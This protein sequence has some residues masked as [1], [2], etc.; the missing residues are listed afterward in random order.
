MTQGCRLLIPEPPTSGF[1]TGEWMVEGGE[2]SD[3]LQTRVTLLSRIKN[4]EDRRAW[5]EFV[6]L[7]GLV[8]YNFCSKRG[9]QSADVEDVV[10]EALRSVASAIQNF[11]YD[12]AKGTF[13]GWLFRVV[14]SKLND[15]FRKAAKREQGTGRTTI[16]RM[17]EE[18][19]SESEIEEWDEEYHRYVFRWAADR[20]K[21]QVTK[22]SWSAFWMTA[23]E[24]RDPAEVANE[25]GME[26][27]AVYVAKSRVIS[28]LRDTVEL[29][30]GEVLDQWTA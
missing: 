2:V 1:Q 10:Q 21:P 3:E 14:R 12:P 8:L 11:E 26:R 15:H 7:Y 25:L 24:E 29:A 6:D 16:L 20:V 4:P 30:A 9:L 13:R 18:T 19:P 22:K 27:G 23:V 17:I 5:A 28:R